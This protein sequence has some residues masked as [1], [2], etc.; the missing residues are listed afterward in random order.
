MNFEL[1]KFYIVDV[2]E[3]GIT[4]LMEFDRSQWFNKDYDDLDFLTDEEKE[5][6]VNGV[7]D[8]IREEIKLAINYQEGEDISEYSI[9]IEEVLQIIDKYRADKEK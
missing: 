5:V 3:R 4:P 7:L 2:T 8:N 1:G 6:I 9:D